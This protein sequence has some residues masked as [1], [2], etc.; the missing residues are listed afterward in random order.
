VAYATGWASDLPTICL[1]FHFRSLREC[2]TTTQIIDNDDDDDELG[3]SCSHHSAPVI[4]QY[5]LVLVSGQ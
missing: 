5:S 1:G 3:A 4:E 2:V